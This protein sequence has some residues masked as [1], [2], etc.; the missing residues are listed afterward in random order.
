MKTLNIVQSFAHCVLTEK[1]L[2]ML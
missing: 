2:R 1:K